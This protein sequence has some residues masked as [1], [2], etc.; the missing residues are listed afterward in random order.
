MSRTV[1]NWTVNYVHE[2]T[3]HVKL[4]KLF[5]YA[6]KTSAQISAWDTVE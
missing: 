1:A 5:F 4:F 2:G 3:P 6:L